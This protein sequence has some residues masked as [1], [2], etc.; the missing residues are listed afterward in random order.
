MKVI[1]VIVDALRYDYLTIEHMPFL[2]SFADKNIY[3]KKVKPGF[4]FC[5]RTEIFTGMTAKKSG[6]FTAIGYDPQNS[7]YRKFRSILKL[8]GKISNSRI[9]NHIRRGL[10]IILSRLGIK[11]S[12]YKIPFNMLPNVC[13]TEDK[14]SHYTYNAFENESIFDILLSED[15][16]FFVDTFTHIGSKIMM[17]DEER[18][19]KIIEISNQGYDFEIVYL[20]KI[21]EMGHK[22]KSKSEVLLRY[23]KE[24]DDYIKDIWETNS[25]SSS[26]VRLAVLG[27]HGMVDV[28]KRI[29]ISKLC[30]KLP[31]TLWHDYEYFIDSTVVRFWFK[32]DDIK[33][34]FE[35]YFSNHQY[36][37]KDFYILSEH[38]A[39]SLHVPINKKSISGEKTYGELILCAREG[40]IFSPDFFHTEDER[41]MG[42]HGYPVE[43]DSSLGFF[44]TNFEGENKIIEQ[45]DLIDVCPTLCKLIDVRVPN[46]NEGNSIL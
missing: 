36:Q 7:E 2:Y 18:V 10:W 44:V 46:G 25:S 21:D 45:F 17:D 30:K 12:M 38:E 5:E 34:Y 8:L 40:V 33:K 32:D 37:N 15:K 6:N 35:E 23:V 16:N 24:I 1:L 22:N 14:K 20:G 11:M 31:Y 9:D 13:L 28:Q 42:M 4:G 26:E 29:D 19:K 43:S 41:I 3:V 27:D 39:D